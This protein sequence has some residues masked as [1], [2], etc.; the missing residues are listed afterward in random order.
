MW[1]DVLSVLCS[2]WPVIHG[3]WRVEWPKKVWVIVCNWVKWSSLIFQGERRAIIKLRLMLRETLLKPHLLVRNFVKHLNLLLL[4]FIL[5]REPRLRFQC[6]AREKLRIVAWHGWLLSRGVFLCMM[7]CQ[8]LMLTHSWW[9]R[10][11]ELKLYSRH[12]ITASTIKIQ[13]SLPRRRTFPSLL[14]FV[15]NLI[16]LF[17]LHC[18]NLVL[19]VFI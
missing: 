6:P 17:A 13:F 11:V 1:S 8:I 3:F 7:I 16:I 18:F 10:W 5:V 14:I 15:H 9:L 12:V 4:P 19:L 2:C